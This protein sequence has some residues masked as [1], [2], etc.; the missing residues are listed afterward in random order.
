MSRYALTALAK[1]DFNAIV[2]YLADHAGAKVA[3]R[4]LTDLREAMRLIAN[5]PSTG[6]TREDLADPPLR[7]FAVHSY[8]VVYDPTRRPV[9]IIRIIHGARDVKNIL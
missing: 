8:L 6:H 2:A 3:R 7:F 4:M 9:E 1:R 5:R